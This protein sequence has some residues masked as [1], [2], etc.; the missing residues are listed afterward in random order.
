MASSNGLFRQIRNRYNFVT[1]DRRISLIRN[2]K[3]LS[4]TRE[5]RFQRSPRADG[6]YLAA[7]SG[8][9]SVATSP[10]P[11]YEPLGQVNRTR[12][13]TELR[14]L[15]AHSHWVEYFRRE[16]YQVSKPVRN[17][18]ALLSVTSLR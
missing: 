14:N 5:I 11:L 6:I 18:P 4:Y 16:R 12:V 9:S 3:R 17:P 1:Y 2:T 7:V 15:H 8:S 10:P 13:R